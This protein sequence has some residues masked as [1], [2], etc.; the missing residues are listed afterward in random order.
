MTMAESDQ[1]IK[2]VKSVLHKLTEYSSYAQLD[3]FLNLYHNSPSFLHFSG[4]GKMRNYDEFKR[5][6]SEY[7]TALAQ[8]KIVT[9]SEKVYVIE[10]NIVITG[11]TGNINAQFKNGD[12]I[13]MSNYSVSNVLKKV[14]GSW[15]IIQSHES[16]LPPEIIRK[17]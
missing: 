10:A 9:I 6:C 12:T 15:K 11:W 7:Y 17:G 2:E 13:N 4:D 5:V 8:Q 1:I 14:N 16:S 3:P